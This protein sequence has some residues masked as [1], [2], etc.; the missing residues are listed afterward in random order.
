[1]LAN[2]PY[3]A[4]FERFIL[5]GC[6]MCGSTLQAGQSEESFPVADSNYLVVK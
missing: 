6:K 2:V 5:D 1:M 3:R 4:R